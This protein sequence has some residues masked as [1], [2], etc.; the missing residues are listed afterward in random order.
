MPKRF[1]RRI[2]NHLADARYEPR[3]IAQL[4]EDLNI[5][6]DEFDEFRQAVHQ[7]LEAGHLIRG[8]E[9]TVA[10]PPPGKEMIGSFRRHERGFGFIMP[11]ELTEHGDL[12][13]PPHQTYDAMT[14]DRVRAKVLHD[15][16][17]G[18][19]GKSPYIGEI[20]EILERADRRY[21][22]TLF[23]RGKSYFVEVDGRQW[24]EPVYIGDPHAKNASL[25]DKV[26]I[27]L[28]NY[29][30]ENGELA[31]GVITEVLGETGEP[32]VETQAVMR[33]FGLKEKF[34][35]S[36]ME[37][38]RR[39]AHAFDGHAV[40]PGRED[41]TDLF[42]C[43]ID[44]PE[45]RDFDDAITVRKLEGSDAAEYLDNAGGG[46]SRQRVV[47]ELGVHIA[48]VCHFVEAN[49][50]LD[51][52]AFER[53]NSTYLP[54]RV[55]PMLPELL[56]NGVCSLQEG[57]NRYCKSVFIH[58]DERGRVLKQRFANTV[59][60]SD[61]RL[62][63]L[64]AQALIDN[65]LR[66]A[67]KHAATEAKYSRKLSERLRV[68]DELSRIIF[69][70]RMEHGMIQLGLPEVELIFDDAGRV[71]DAQP[72][73][74]AYTHTIIEMF[75]VEANEAAARLFDAYHIPMLRRVHPDPDAHSMGDL[76]SFAQVAGY[77]I[78]ANPDRKQL[79][80]LIE[81]VRGKP[82]QHAVHLAVLKTL[83]KAEYS[84]TPVGHFALASE[85]YTHF[86]SPIRRYPDLIVHRGLQAL[87]EAADGQPLTAGLTG[88]P[89]R[90]VRAKQQFA[91]RE[92][93]LPDEQRL[94]EIGTHCS[95]TER[96]S[97][98]AER[99]LRNYLLLEMLSDHLGDDYEGTVAGVTGGGLFI[100][101]DR[102]LVDG[103]VPV[104]EL[105][106]AKG[107]RW[108]L[109]PN[110]GAL[111]AQRS[112]KTV[113]IG[114][115]FVVRIAQI[116]LARRRMELVVVKQIAA[117]SHQ[118][119]AGLPS[120]EAEQKSGGRSGK[121]AGKKKAGQRKQSKGAAA[122]HQKSQKLKQKQKSERSADG[123][124]AKAS[125]ASKKK[126]GKKAGKKRG[127]TKSSKS[128]KQ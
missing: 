92:A 12:F 87:L 26:V 125:K 23:K 121:K 62:T 9:D 57:V 49:G 96:N 63:Y 11:D 55:L 128:R 91:E 77:N 103:F 120:P 108:Q 95:T 100:E 27:E 60:R 13:V 70:R 104:S 102:F 5:P 107:D 78:P 98:S 67:R 31:E 90:E 69:K 46:Q 117:R 81:S 119:E 14:G 15:P 66:E 45:A 53:G 64:E 25:G 79:Q 106:S 37:E 127:G 88:L 116:D 39:V 122:A 65:D 2:L 54:R 3:T 4:A 56:S 8:S 51:G 118:G 34:T 32:E 22:G 99:E 59:M 10:L 7:L 123:P 112:G 82:A 105:P 113:N 124:P 68:M 36:V 110:S 84:P 41:H 33:S 83:S 109:N 75:M 20:V 21:T 74:D 115:R 16:R 38:A 61:K 97:E 72:E 1:S 50:E 76:S 73:D 24:H 42:T 89:K 17:R 18:G 52:E 101:L 6:D 58:L 126:G 71:I 44:P 35:D 94:H 30:G 19:G 111:V 43:T 48:D 28:V 29:P 114:D 40:P 47:Y 86:T 93:R 80:Q 85:H